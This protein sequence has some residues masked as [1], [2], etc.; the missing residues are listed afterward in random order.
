VDGNDVVAVRHIVG[1]ALATARRGGGPT[2]VEALTYRLS[3]HTTSDD[4]SHYRKEQEVKDAWRMEPL[5]RVRAH[6]TNA[7]AWDEARE[8]KL[9]AECTQ[10]VDAA[11]DE[12][13]RTP[14]QGTD[15]MFDFL[16]ANPPR[17]L[18]AQRELARSYATS[19][20]EREQ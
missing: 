9:K 16:F 7:G 13:F 10:Q 14:K 1:E 4:A 2:V 3:D 19:E 20:E 11:V 18:E 12:Y 17:T 6:L 5:L 8:V 15:S